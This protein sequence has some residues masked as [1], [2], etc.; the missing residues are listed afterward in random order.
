MNPSETITFFLIGVAVLFVVVVVWILF[1]KRKKWAIG[2]TC[3]LV[4]G[5]IGSVAYYPYLQVSI[6]AERY[7]QVSEYLETNYPDREFTVIPEYYE[8]GYTVGV[9]D[10]S[11]KETPDIGV[12]LHVDDN[13]EVQQ[14]SHWTD[15]GFPT[16][17]EL[18]RELEFTYGEAYTLDKDDVEITKQD[19]WIEGELTVFALTIDNMPAIAI[20]EYSKGGYGLLDL[21]VEKNDFVISAEA[22]GYTFIYVDERYEDEKAA[23]Q[24]ENRETISVNT[25]DH[26]GK[27]FVVE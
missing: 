20:Y 7:E 23:I 3:I 27:L 21:Q 4:A 17:Q 5:Y 2:L 15:G 9:F 13:D 6:H 22:D 24:L 11:D 12:T 16:Q 26:G 19:E 14:V 8:A 1:R 10:V 18:W 25:A